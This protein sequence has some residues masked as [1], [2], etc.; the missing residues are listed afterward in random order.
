MALFPTTLR[1]QIKGY[2][3]GSS[4]NIVSGLL[5]NGGLPIYALDSTIGPVLFDIVVLGDDLE[6]QVFTDFLYGNINSGADRFDMELEDG[7]GISSQVVSIIPESISY[8]TA[9]N[10]TW[11]INFRVIAEFTVAQ[12]LAV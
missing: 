9:N 10:P 5:E 12:G 1:P 8:T 4:E 11:I 2:G 7:L 6:K 3:F